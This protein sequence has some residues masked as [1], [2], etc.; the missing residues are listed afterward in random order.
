MN[1]LQYNVF[2]KLLFNIISEK[3]YNMIV[4]EEYLCFSINNKVFIYLKDLLDL[5]KKL[6]T[7]FEITFII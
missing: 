3:R 6:K 1:I 7:D 5:I 4:T 2:S